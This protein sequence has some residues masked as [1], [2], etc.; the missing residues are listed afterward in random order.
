MGNSY[1]WKGYIMESLAHLL[2]FLR[3]W[4][5]STPQML[6]ARTVWGC[7]VAW[8][9]GQVRDFL[10]RDPGSKKRLNAISGIE[11]KSISI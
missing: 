1:E 9:G 2:W 6:D 11:R 3:D 4:V 7:V 10:V 5:L 8:G